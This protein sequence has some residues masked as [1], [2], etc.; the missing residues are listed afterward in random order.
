MGIG[1]WAQCQRASAQ[2]E[3]VPVSPQAALEQQRNELDAQGKELEKKKADRKVALEQM[4]EVAAAKK[5]LDTAETALQD[6]IKNNPDYAKL[7]KA[8]DEASAAYR[9]AYE[10][11]KSADTEYAAIRKQVEE[12]RAKRSEIE[13][14]INEAKAK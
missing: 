10:A 9:T 14:K 3:V 13:K 6:F 11:A 1:L 12:L 2:A 4:T 5:A 7:L 8:R